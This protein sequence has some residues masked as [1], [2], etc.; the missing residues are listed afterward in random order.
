MPASSCAS[1]RTTR[2]PLRRPPLRRWDVSCF[3]LAQQVRSGYA[4]LLIALPPEHWPRWHEADPAGL[5]RH[6][7]RLAR[8][9][10]P[11]AAATSKRGPKTAKPKGHV[12]GKTA[13]G[14]VA[15]APVLAQAKTTP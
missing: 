9:I 14:H 13:R 5:A 11:R 10:N 3:H 1:T 4:G 8:S 12:D 2:P 6:L 7:L 15:T